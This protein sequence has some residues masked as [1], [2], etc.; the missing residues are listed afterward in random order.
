[1]SARIAV[2]LDV[3][4]RSIVAYAVAISTGEALTR[5]FG[6]GDFM[7][8]LA[9]LEALPG[10]CEAVYEAGYCGFSLARFLIDHSVPCTVTQGCTLGRG[11]A[12][13]DAMDAEA[14]SRLLIASKLRPVFI[15]T[16]EQE[17]RREVARQRYELAQQRKAAKHRLAAF[18]HR[19]GLPKNIAVDSRTRVLASLN[20]GDRLSFEALT[21]QLEN[22]NREIAHLEKFMNREVERDP[23]M[24]ALTCISGIGPVVSFTA[25]AEAMDFNRFGTARDYVSF[26]GLVPVPHNSG[27]KSAR[28]SN[29]KRTVSGDC[30]YSAATTVMRVGGLFQTGGLADPENGVIRECLA[31]LDGSPCERRKTHRAAIMARCIAEQTWALAH[32]LD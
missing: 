31:S 28:L 8:L 13:T 4:T 12:K 16:E 17:A 29:E 24:H 20:P 27:G 25:T 32:R 15:P 14:L 18:S 3:H 30:F 22:A 26:L 7:G 11:R 23:S 21:A 10:R 6:G 2:G 9:W 5:T 19:H 1:M